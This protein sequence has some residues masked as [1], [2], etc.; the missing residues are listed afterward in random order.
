MDKEIEQKQ[1]QVHV[2]SVNDLSYFIIHHLKQCMFDVFL[3]Y[4]RLIHN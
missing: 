3:A 1:Q 2:D 4:T